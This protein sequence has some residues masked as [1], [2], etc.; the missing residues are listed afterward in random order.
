MKKKYVILGSVLVIGALLV[1][2]TLAW[3]TW[4]TSNEQNTNVAVTV[5]GLPLVMKMEKI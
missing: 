2:A 4:S 1:G 3:F 5:E